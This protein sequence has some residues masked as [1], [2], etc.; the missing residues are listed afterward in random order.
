MDRLELVILKNL[1]QNESYIRRV[2]PFLKAEYFQDSSERVLF[3]VITNFIDKYNALPTTEA[4]LIDV[5]NKE[6]NQSEVDS[7]RDVLRDFDVRA[8][9]LSVND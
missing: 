9:V 5:D 8:D 2:I 6:I 4:L 3:D 1:T 7:I